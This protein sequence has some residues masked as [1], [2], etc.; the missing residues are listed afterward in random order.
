[1][2]EWKPEILRRLAPLKLAPTR[3]AEITD[4]LAQHLEDRYQEL[5]ATGHSEDAAFRTAIDELK[6]EDFL[7][8][9][10]RPVERDW[11]RESI[12]VGQD[13][14][15]VFSGISQD[16]R[17][18]LRMLRKSPGFT[19]VAVLTLA[20]GIGANTAIFSVVNAILLEPLPYPEP[21]RIAAIW[22]TDSKRGEASRSLSYPDFQDLQ[23]QNNAFQSTAV[24]SDSTTS[25][26]GT[27]EPLHL[28]EEDIT[29]EMFSVLGVHPLL[30][31]D[32][33]PGEDKP[34]HNVVIISYKLWQGQFGGDRNIIGRSVTFN[35]RDYT[36][37]GVLPASF[38]F[39]FNSDG[40]DVWRTFSQNATPDSSGEKPMTEERGAHFLRALGR[41]K[42]GVSFA[43]ANQAADTIGQRLAKQ[44][45]DEN[46][47][48]SFRVEPALDGLVGKF[49]AQLFILLG[50]VGL[51]LLIGCANIAN[52]L[53]ARATARQREMAVR[54]AL[55]AGR[56]RIVRQLLIES[57]ML[58]L[59]GGACGLAIAPWGAAYLAALGTNQ[60]PRL[61]GAALDLRVLAFTFAASVLT[62]LLFG[63]APA[64][65]LSH[66]PLAEVLKEGG[67]S[68]SQ[69][70]GQQRLRNL[71]IISETALA[72]MLLVSAGLLIESLGNMRKVSPGFNPHGV[73]S[74]ALDI[75]E[76]RYPTNVK[77]EQFYEQVIAHIRTI[78]GVESAS[79]IVPLPFSDSRVHVTYQIEG[80]IVQPGDAPSVHFRCVG[81]DYFRTMEVPLLKG[82]VIAEN[83]REGTPEVI[84]INKAFADK[85]YPG[86]DPIGKRIKPD[87]SEL[88]EAPWRE[89]VGVVGDVKVQ[90]LDHPDEPEIYIPE[91]QLGIDW[92]FGVVRTSVPLE[93]LVPAIREQMHAV[94]KDVPIYSVRTMDDYVAKSTA[95]PRLDSALLA[96]FAGLALVLAMVG[97]YGVMSY[98]VAQRTNE[99]GIRM[100]LGAQRNDM[101]SLVLKQGLAVAAIGAA[102]GIA[103]AIGATR[104]LASL[105]FGVGPGDPL[106]LIA[107]SVLLLVCALVACYIPARRAMH[108]D[109]LVALR[110]E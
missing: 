22:G 25:L 26:T 82:R 80:R 20:L 2:P 10:L 1:M 32:F 16:I 99:F 85:N 3:E 36:I 104:L 15:N 66:Q 43:Q 86:E 30:G 100:T 46:K 60:F 12:A 40:P 47:Y 55:G 91:N 27:G 93:G 35:T 77:H 65:Q 72:V 58:S 14:N 101:L 87:V 69:G 92:Q 6:G 31:R 110:Y 59:A 57:G 24:Y 9:G 108:V 94:D 28:V 44:Y 61:A 78:P 13:S 83:D 39:P 84:V 71:L 29:T 109:P 4:E 45:P 79:T 76:S 70:R 107:V 106:T 19:A 95:Q 64:L 49:R 68:A 23:A 33:L 63:V 17:Y 62:G 41:L 11:Y 53:L 8:R 105:L 54:T 74:F 38:D 75:P 88:G 90:G 103:A 34:G 52:L 50:A 102:V 5:L 67:R 37:V 89:V 7:A 48:T 81:T 98:G 21:N 96:L 51:V 42:S 18:A 97:I 56:L 73:L